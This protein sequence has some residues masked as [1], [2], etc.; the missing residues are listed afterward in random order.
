MYKLNNKTKFGQ[1]VANLANKHEISPVE[2]AEYSG[3]HVRKLMRILN[4][5]S[6]LTDFDMMWLVEC[7]SDLTKRDKIDMIV[8]VAKLYFNTDD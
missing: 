1:W 4:G 8:E 7:L 2:I 5:D 3:I 6:K